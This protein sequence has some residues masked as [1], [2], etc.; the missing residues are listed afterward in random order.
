VANAII[1]ALVDAL[2][3]TCA[4]EMSAGVAAHATAAAPSSKLATRVFTQVRLLMIAIS[5]LRLNRLLIEWL[6]SVATP[7]GQVVASTQKGGNRGRF[8]S[9][10]EK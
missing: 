2:A 9:S 4:E 3:G 6:K 7:M 8:A 10:D 5:V 1:P